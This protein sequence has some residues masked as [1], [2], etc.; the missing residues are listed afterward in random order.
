ML[1]SPSIC[2]YNLYGERVGAIA[3]E[4]VHVELISQRARMC[5]GTITPHAHPGIFQ[6]LLLESG[7]R[8]LADAA[9]TRLVLLLTLAED[10]LGG[11]DKLVDVAMDG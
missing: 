4:F 8:L 6:I 1:D 10:A 9:A 2:R 7:G 5:E 3:P 11:V